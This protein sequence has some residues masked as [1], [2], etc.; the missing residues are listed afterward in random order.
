MSLDQAFFDD[1]YAHPDDDGLRLI[2][3]D[4]LEENGQ[5]ER[6][7]LIRIQLELEELP[8]DHPRRSDLEGRQQELLKSHGR[9]WKSH[10]PNLVRSKADFR[11]G[12]L[13]HIVLTAAELLREGKKLRRKVYFDSLRLRSSRGMIGKLLASGLL[14]GLR[15]LD[16][17]GNSLS[18]DEVVRLSASPYLAELRTLVISHNDFSDDACLAL[19]T[20]PFLTKLKRL[21]AS[22]CNSALISALGDPDVAFRP[23]KVQ[24]VSGGVSAE[25]VRALANAPAMSSLRELGLSFN[26][27][28]PDGAFAIAR[29]PYLKN[30]RWLSV[31]SCRLDDAAV[32]ELV[33]SPNAQFL[34]II[35]LYQNP[36]GPDAARAVASSPYMGNLIHIDFNETKIG[37]EGLKALARSTHLPRLISLEMQNSGI[38]SAGLL[39]LS[40]GRLLEQLSILSLQ[41][42]SRI[43]SAGVRALLTQ[44][45][46][47]LKRL[48]LDYC[49]VEATGA[50]AIAGSPH[51]G[52]LESLDL[53]GN[54]IGSKPMKL[55]ANSPHLTNLKWLC[56]RHNGIDDTGAGAILDSSIA[57][58]LGHLELDGNDISETMQKQ[59]RKQFGKRVS[60]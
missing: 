44:K 4:W 56:L 21:E 1:I 36:I 27:F 6:G 35:G 49:R 22:W 16:L 43:G 32:R 18:D 24:M 12:I 46:A 52:Q 58:R 47:R 17:S 29:S 37:N 54:R 60:L 3:A 59:L 50:R 15:S 11:R 45:A 41:E 26:P 57:V 5:P 7:E 40:K 28:G 38:S 51:L 25:E 19:A 42:N 23:Q 33:H 2:Y 30:L 9:K 53:S 55:L 20:S 8:E 34:E 31:W 13:S 48:N 14:A 10:L 39:E